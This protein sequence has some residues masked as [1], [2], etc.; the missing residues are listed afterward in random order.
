MYLPELHRVR[1][2]TEHPMLLHL[3][4]LHYSRQQ[5]IKVLLVPMGNQAPLA[6]NH[7]SEICY[8]KPS[9]STCSATRMAAAASL[10]QLTIGRHPACSIRLS[11]CLMLPTVVWKR[12]LVSFTCSM[13]GAATNT[14]DG[15]VD[16]CAI[17]RVQP[18]HV[19]TAVCLKGKLDHLTVLFVIWILQDVAKNGLQRVNAGFQCCWVVVLIV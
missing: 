4:H 14:S 9:V 19:R 17:T 13:Q 16:D 6:D 10:S 12:L 5:H 15:V 11:A 2:M 8:L 3:Y 1:C 7:V 18:L